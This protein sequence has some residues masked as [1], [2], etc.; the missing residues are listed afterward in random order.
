MLSAN[1]ICR[2]WFWEIIY[3]YFSILHTAH[4]RHSV[5]IKEIISVYFVL[6]IYAF[7]T[8]TT[9]Y[10][11]VHNPE[12]W[13]Y[14]LH[15]SHQSAIKVTLL[16]WHNK[17]IDQSSTCRSDEWNVNRNIIALHGRAKRKKRHLRQ[18]LNSSHFI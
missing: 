11:I 14:Q 5:R 18:K 3:R 13:S 12:N 17:N 7:I 4:D 15:R 1:L 9:G 16:T 10:I 6:T 2:L 8:Y